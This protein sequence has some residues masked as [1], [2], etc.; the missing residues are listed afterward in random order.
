MPK[1]Q[2]IESNYT[3]NITPIITKELMLAKISLSAI[4]ATL[5]IANVAHANPTGT[6]VSDPIFFNPTTDEATL[7]SLG[8]ASQTFGNTTIYIG[9]NQVSANNQDPILTSFTNGV[10]DWL[11]TDYDTSAADARGLGLLWD[12]GS[13]LY[14]A[15]TIDGGTPPGE[16]FT[17]F[18]QD[19]WLSSYGSGGGAKATVLLQI[20]AAT[21]VGIGGTYVS[22]ELSNGNT[23]T[24]LPTGLA[25]D[26]DGNV[27]LDALSFFFPRDID[28]STQEQTEFSNSPFPYTIVFDPTLENAL[29]AVSPGFNGVP[30]S[31]DPDP[32]VQTPEPATTI[33]SLFALGI[34]TVIK[35]KK[36]RA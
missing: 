35:R 31:S 28:G 14:A 8:A 11:I 24:L 13:S 23:N 6:I 9:T 3:C 27:V 18:T 22:A 1:P 33:M 20:D 4:A 25:F 10:R 17:Q 29:S 36:S 32:V 26:D 30:L 15:F 21:G 16:G 7:Q 12:G 34:V 19:G 2:P 5:A